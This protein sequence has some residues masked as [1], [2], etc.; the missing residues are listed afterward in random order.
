M[1]FIDYNGNDITSIIMQPNDNILFNSDWMHS[2]LNKK[3][4]YLTTRLVHIQ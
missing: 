3:E 4:N 2:I 1:E